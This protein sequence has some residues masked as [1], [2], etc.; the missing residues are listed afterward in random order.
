MMYVSR[1][2]NCCKFSHYYAQSTA[3]AK[4]YAIYGL[5]KYLI[6]QF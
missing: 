6:K 1:C 3:H 5:M 2:E 4:N